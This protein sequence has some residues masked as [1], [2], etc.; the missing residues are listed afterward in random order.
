MAKQC[1]AVVMRL[2]NQGVSQYDNYDFN[3]FCKIGDVYFG[4]NSSGIFSLGGD[5]DNGTDIDSIFSLILSDWGV[6]NVKR[7]RKIYIGYETN[8]SL[9]IKV[10]N[11]EDN[12]RSYTLPYRL[13]DRQG[14]NTVNVGRDGAGRYWGI[15]VENVSGADFAIDSIEVLPVVLNTRRS[16]LA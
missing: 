7:I 11:E 15:R 10:K 5:D 3:S 14:G 13:Y 4:A 9:I 6:S 8:G 1:I 12:E 2:E 16:M